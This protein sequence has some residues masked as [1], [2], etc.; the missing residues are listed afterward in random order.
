MTIGNV[1][2]KESSRRVVLA[3]IHPVETLGFKT[4]R[5]GGLFSNQTIKLIF[6]KSAWNKI[7]LNVM[8]N[9]GVLLLSENIK[10]TFFLLDRC[11]ELFFC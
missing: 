7:K 5:C 3:F 8:F 4:L 2:K 10:L 11:Y 1:V 6:L 9:F